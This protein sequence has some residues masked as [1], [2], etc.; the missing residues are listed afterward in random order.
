MTAAL[1]REHCLQAG[2]KCISQELINW[3]KGTALIRYALHF[4]QAEL[5][6]GYNN[7]TFDKPVFPLGK[8]LLRNRFPEAGVDDYS[9][10]SNSV[11]RRG[12]L[13]LDPSLSCQLRRPEHLWIRSL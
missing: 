10:S 6:L 3:T 2:L 7:G 9:C 12:A 11:L 13:S 4:R 1:F 8:R 5:A